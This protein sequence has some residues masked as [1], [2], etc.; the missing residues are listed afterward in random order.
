MIPRANVRTKRTFPSPSSVRNPRPVR[1]PIRSNRLCDSHHSVA[2][3]AI[4][5]SGI[6]ALFL[7]LEILEKSGLSVAV[8]ERASALCAGATGAG[9]GYLWSIHRDPFDVESWKRAI[10]GRRRWQELAS[11]DDSVSVDVNGSL[12]LATT[13]REKR[14]L[15]ARVE[16]VNAALGDTKAIFL[17]S[18]EDVERIEP[19]LKQSVAPIFAGA[20]LPSDCQIDGAATTRAI[21]ARCASYGDRFIS[22]FDSRVDN[23]LI[24]GGNVR[25]I[26]CDGG[27]EIRAGAVCVCAGAW[28]STLISSWLRDID[29]DLAQLWKN[30]IVPRRGHLLTVRPA[31]SQTFPR[32]FCCLNHGI[33]ESS[34]SKHY[35]SSRGE[36]EYDVTFTATEDHSNGTLLIGSS[37]EMYV[38]DDVVDERV[39]KDILT[40]A[41]KYLP[42]LLDRNTMTVLETRVGLRP[43]SATGPFIGPVEGING[44]FVAAGHEGSGLTLAPSTAEDMLECLLSGL[45]FPAD[46]GLQ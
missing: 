41:R 45:R 4:V 43:F 27:L 11:L 37:R 14:A 40:A 32:G 10:R 2:D 23:L 12:L 25:G 38:Y 8:V 5:G 28:S 39:V 42:A 34:Y 30:K 20:T 35:S 22:H 1:V 36:D 18:R 31:H 29:H 26:A 7:A 3:I 46:G 15:R 44:L 24:E 6:I 33:M 13:L 17:S 16:A 21:F 19:A 9:Q